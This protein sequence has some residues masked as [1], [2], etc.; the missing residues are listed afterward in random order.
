M[1][2]TIVLGLSQGGTVT[3]LYGLIGIAIINVFLALSLGELASAY[4]SA[5]GQYVWS[6]CLAGPR[7]R[8]AVSFAVGWTT[9]FSWVTIVAS[10]VIILAEVVFALVQLYSPAFVIQ[11]W[12]IFLVFLAVNIISVTFNIFGAVRMPWIGKAFFY[13]SSVVALCILITIVARAPTYN[14]NEFVWKTYSN[15]TGWDSSFVVVSLGLVNTGYIWAGLDGA[16]H[17]AEEAEQ[18]E[19]AVPLTLLSTVGMGF[20]TGMAMALSLIYTVQDIDAAIDSELPFLTII[21]QASRSEAAGTVFMVAF[22]ICLLVSANSV[23]HATGRLIW[24]F[25]RDNGLPLSDAIK[26][27]HPTL[28][29]PVWPLIISG[30]GVTI[31]GVLYVA[32]TTLYSSIIACCIILGNISFAIPAVQLLLNGRKL[33]EGRWMKLGWL[34]ALANVVTILFTVF[35]TIMWLF[36][37]VR[38]PSSSEMNYSVA[39]LGGMALIAIVDWFGEHISLITRAELKLT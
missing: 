8:R 6:A 39:V 30:A 21:V 2:S 26:R 1:G 10:V 38:D 16:I 31:L 5:G 14:S 17:I 23:H 15:G 36:P 11:R 12:H 22:L 25:A 9:I 20:V 3:V 19:K 32:N 4:P 27:V 33:P 24:S 13:F 7:S 34:G 35:T 37:T 29:V 18:P 28:G